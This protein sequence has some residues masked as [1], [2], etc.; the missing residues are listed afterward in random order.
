M[1]EAADANSLV[2]AY[3][4]FIR[5]YDWDWWCHLTFAKAPPLDRALRTLGAWM[6]GLNKKTFG[7]GYA[8][9]GQGVRWVRGTEC[10][11]TGAYHFHLLLAGC[12]E[13]HTD[14]GVKSWLKLAGDAKIQVYDQTGGA[15]TYIAKVYGDSGALAFGGPWPPLDLS[16]IS[17]L[18]AMR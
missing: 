6:N 1:D 9:R 7:N 16:E 18:N 12:Q 10:Q 8:K 4:A 2:A 11:K 3:A 17:Q 14:V 15:P 13:I 5:R